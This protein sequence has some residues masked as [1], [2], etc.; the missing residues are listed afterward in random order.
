[1]KNQAIGA[2]KAAALIAAL[3]FVFLYA[4]AQPTEGWIRESA[5]HITATT[6]AADTDLRGVVTTGYDIV[7]HNKNGT[8]WVGTLPLPKGRTAQAAG[9]D[10]FAEMTVFVPPNGARIIRNENIIVLRTVSESSSADLIVERE[11][12]I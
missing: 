7:V 12:R 10:T 2:L 8:I 4:Q 5:L 9:L 6:S 11:K 3:A 1:M